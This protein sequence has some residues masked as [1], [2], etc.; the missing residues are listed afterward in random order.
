MRCPLCTAVHDEA[1]ARFIVSHG[2]PMTEKALNSRC[3]QYAKAR[4][5]QGC[6]NPCSEVDPS[7]T[8]EARMGEI[9][10]RLAVRRQVTEVF[11]P[12]YSD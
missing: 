9:N 7:E 2:P 11:I 4:G 3:C 8:L 6:I 12:T 10:R 5:R 1:N